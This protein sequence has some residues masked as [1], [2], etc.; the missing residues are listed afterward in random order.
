VFSERPASLQRNHRSHEARGCDLRGSWVARNSPARAIGR[1]SVAD[2]RFHASA[3]PRGVDAALE[4]RQAPASPYPFYACACRPMR[5]TGGGSYRLPRANDTTASLVR[6]P[7]TLTGSLALA[8]R[9]TA[10]SCAAMK[11]TSGASSREARPTA[12]GTLEIR[13]ASPQS[14]HRFFQGMAATVRHGG[15][16]RP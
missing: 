11:F 13:A 4:S 2:A 6:D 1:L 16:G 3:G 14:G 5:G 7:W 12:P 10:A 8:M 9:M 15:T